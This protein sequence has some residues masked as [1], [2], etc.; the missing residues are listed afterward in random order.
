MLTELK[1]TN[2]AI[3]D[4]LHVHFKQGL[5]ILSGETGAGKSVLLKSLALLM[6]GKSSGDIVRTGAQQATIEGLFDLSDR[7]DSMQLLKDHGFELEEKTLVVRR[8]L[9]AGDKSKIYMNGSLSTLNTLR[10]VVAP[11]IEVAGH[12]APLIEMTG[13]H[14][15]KNL[16]S[17]SYHLDLLD[18]YSGTWDKRLLFEEK[19][20]RQ[21]EIKQEIQTLTLEAQQ[22]VQRLDFLNYQRN[23]IEALGLDESKDL[24]LDI[25]VRKLKNSARLSHFVDQAETALYTDEDSAFV[26]IQSILKKSTELSQIDPD[27]VKKLEG[28]ESAKTLI[29][30]TIYELRKYV[31]KI[32][33]DPEHLE[34]L[35]SRLSDLKKL[36]K[37]YGPQIS[38][39]FENL[40]K[41]KL[42]ISTLDQS[43]IKIEALKKESQMIAKDLQKLSDDLHARRSQGAKLLSESVNAELLDLNMKGVTFHVQVKKLEELSSSGISDVEFM[44]QTSAKDP[45]KPLAKFASGGELS[46]ILLS[47]KRVVGSTS[48][49]RTYIFDEVDT[50]VSGETAE[51]V[52]KKL[53]STAKGQQVI[54]VTHLP[55]VAAFGDIHYFIQKTTE[56]GQAHM[57]VL[58]LTNKQRVQ[59]IARLISGEKITK[60]SLAHAQELLELAH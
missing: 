42:E 34:S 44:S 6:G 55:Q 7:P 9:S 30:E 39:I 26:R 14:E 56:K 49:P 52:G 17:K 16:M 58:E 32:D 25:E 37:K 47:L 36:Q 43:D 31:S 1:V 59:E 27:L 60:T 53:R 8:V 15:N 40:K 21:N 23:E 35:E 48:Q 29:D 22:I 12:S 20:R 50:G 11:L 33:A 24:E 2:F 13:Q 19:Y 41:I 51:K 54:C 46:R 4:N 28:L 10:D 3:I 5:N 18:Q 45:Q 57:S 38:D